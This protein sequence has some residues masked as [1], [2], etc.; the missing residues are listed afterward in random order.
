MA[1]ELLNSSQ[2]V[3]ED[4]FYSSY[5]I[6][7]GNAERYT[8]QR[9]R[10]FK[11]DEPHEMAYITVYDHQ[12]ENKTIGQTYST[13]IDAAKHYKGDIGLSIIDLL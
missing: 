6:S 9:F 5:T 13:K 3:S 7:V 10:P 8:I 2:V 11:R 1:Y 4:G 12:Q